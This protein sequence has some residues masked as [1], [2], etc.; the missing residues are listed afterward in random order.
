MKKLLTLICCLTIFGNLK[1]QVVFCPPGA[2]WHYVYNTFSMDPTPDYEN[3][4]A[5]NGGTA[6]VDGE[7][8]TILKHNKIFWRYNTKNIYESYLKQ[9]GDTIFIKNAFTNSKWLIL[10]N[11]AA[12]AGQSWVTSLSFSG[13]SYTVTIDSV[14]SSSAN[15]FTLKTLHALYKQNNPPRFYHS[16]IT[17]RIGGYYYLFNF[18]SGPVT[19]GDYMTDRLCY[20]DSAFGLLQ[21]SNKPCDYSNLTVVSELNQSSQ[22]KIYP[23]PATEYINIDF[24]TWGPK[25]IFITTVLGETISNL[26]VQSSDTSLH[27]NVSE[28]KTGIYF[29][30]ILEGKNLIASKKII[31]N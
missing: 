5:W 22:I 23:N 4:R 29:L 11:Y 31:R 18:F 3:I 21:F 30:K 25:Q 2:E 26:D 15:G 27:L 8:V 28:L 16:S 9:I 24:E 6:L 13:V 1:S 14:T 10:F 20:Q 17:E 12:T 7:T 19:D